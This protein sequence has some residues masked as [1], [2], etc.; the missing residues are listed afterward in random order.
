MTAAAVNAPTS[1][2]HLGRQD[3]TF[4]SISKLLYLGEGKPVR[5]TCFVG[6]RSLNKAAYLGGILSNFWDMVCSLSLALLPSILLLVGRCTAG[7]FPSTDG[8]L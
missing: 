2:L 3:L 8:H 4:G 6:N 7:P 1:R 5:V